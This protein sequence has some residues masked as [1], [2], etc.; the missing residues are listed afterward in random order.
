M[1]AAVLTAHG[2]LLEI[3]E[4]PRPDPGPGE[5]LVRVAGVGACHSDLTVASGRSR[6]MFNLPAILGH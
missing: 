3:R 4:I 5:V 2:E 1:K 6:L